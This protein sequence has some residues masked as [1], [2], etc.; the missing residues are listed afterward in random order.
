MSGMND[1]PSGA[2]SA[3]YSPE[4]N[5]F[6]LYA[7]E[8]LDADTYARVNA[9]GFSWAPRQELFVAGCWTPEREDLLLE[10][11]DEIEDEDTSLAER[12][13][14]R[15][16]RFEGYSGRRGT[17]AEAA[18]KHVESISQRF[19]MGQPIIVGHHSEKR[20][21]RDAD[22]MQNGM[23]K[24]VKLW[25]TAKYWE[26]R[27]ERVQAHVDYKA[28]PRVRANRIKTLEA[29]KRKHERTVKNSLVIA[30]LWRDIART[31]DAAV[32]RVA[33]L[34]VAND[35]RYSFGLWGDLKDGKI[36]PAE[37]AEKA[38]ASAERNIAH[39]TRW[40]A[41]LDNRLAYERV[42]LGRAPDEETKVDR[43]RRG[44]A[45]LPLLNYK[46]E[47]IETRCRWR[48]GAE[49]LRQVAMTAA[50]Y[51]RIY[52]ES[53][54]TRVSA[55]GSHRIRVTLLSSGGGRGEDVVVFLSDSKAHPVPVPK[56][57][58][59]EPTVEEVEAEI[60]AEEAARAEE[61]DEPVDET[62]T[63]PVAF[64][65]PEPAPLSPFEAMRASLKHGVK[66]VAVP[67]LFETQTALAA[68]VV[69]AAG[70]AAGD[71]VLEPSAGLGALAKAART[72][73]GDVRCVEINYA[74][75]DRLRALGFETRTA[76]FLDLSPDDFPFFFDVVVMNPPF[77]KQADID[78][79]THAL[80]FLAP[81]GRLFAIMS[82]AVQFRSNGKAKAFREL[83]ASHG[84]EISPL[85]DGSFQMSGTNVGTCL[86]TLRA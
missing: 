80:R 37:A 83:V 52:K 51:Q 72:A 2:Y 41:H 1:G 84:G 6:R 45:A 62:P 5:K 4:D 43:T 8:R 38:I 16:E 70:V 76:D 57:K 79:V 55:D 67:Q 17:E 78:H 21:R 3:T 36:T 34:R 14:R 28:N 23:A 54:W 19:E 31:E 48:A 44:A 32:Q 20:A 40:I 33:A 77:A 35:G 27:A 68:R 60:A 59:P 58:A 30:E 22:K 82:A 66:A 71:L 25:D 15:A 73:G 13:A 63:E 39:A 65:A 10:L 42:L 56:P 29:E 53:R 46:A 75:A 49:T 12:A 18:R 74:A 26:S 69:E 11:C 47:R 81:R 64:V 50:E 24:A 61:Q 9:A 86:V 7:T 85:P